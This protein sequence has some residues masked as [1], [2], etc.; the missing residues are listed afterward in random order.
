MAKKNSSNGE[1]S[2]GLFA[3]LQKVDKN[4]EVLEESAYSNISD[5]VSTGSYIL[6]ACISGDMFK[7]IP[8]GR[9]TCLSGNS[10]TGKTY[11]AC[12]ICREAQKKGY[13]VLYLDSENAMDKDFAARLGCDTTNFYIKQVNTISE[14]SQ[15]IIN[16]C[17]ALAESGEKQKVVIVLDSLGNLT[18]DKE[19][20]DILSGSNKVDFTKAKDVKAMFRTC[21]IPVAKQQIPWIV[22]NHVYQ[23]IGSYV[24]GTVQASGSGLLYNASNII[25]LTAAKLEDKENDKNAA[26]Q[27]GDAPK[28]NG[29]LVSAT[30]EKSR[31]SI[32]RK[33]KF[34]IPF[35]KKPSPYVGLEQYL[36]W[37]NAGIMQ[38]K[39]LTEDEWKNLKPGE[40]AE[41]K[42]FEYN[43]EKMY[44]WP[45]IQMR[46][47]VG[48]VCKHLG[49]QVTV[50]E[51][52][53]EKVFTDEFLHY[54]NDNIIKP[55]FQL[56]DQNSFDD[57]KELEESLNIEN[58]MED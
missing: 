55:L 18:S 48:I 44:A 1:K 13:S 4:V 28:K 10:G 2:E 39:C 45:K 53:T 7:G 16:F 19:R 43:G 50:Q 49:A 27:P 11:L 33:V 40:Q 24:G 15:F 42:E 56:P 8:A 5:W 47:G 34:Q 9:T 30:P 17:K 26:K 29:V 12:S 51:F 22:V 32:P 54:I 25:N 46:A 6:N 41:C 38:G 57:I 31:F 14:T 35:F 3:I 52:F 21:T 20:D 23:N 37:D 58:K 36:N